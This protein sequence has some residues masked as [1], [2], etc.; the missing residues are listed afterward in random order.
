MPLPMIE[1]GVMEMMK[2]QYLIVDKIANKIVYM[3][4][5][6]IESHELSTIGTRAIDLK[7]IYSNTY[8]MIKLC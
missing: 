4:T 7:H 8:V 5:V 3:E 1:R 2:I 6:E